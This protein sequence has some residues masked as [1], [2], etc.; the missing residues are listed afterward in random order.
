[1]FI[2][3]LVFAFISDN[4]YILYEANADKLLYGIFTD[5]INSAVQSLN[6]I[7]LNLVSELL[8]APHTINKPFLQ[9]Y[10]PNAN[11]LLV[12][13]SEPYEVL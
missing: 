2:E 10:E 5:V 12:V 11:V 13:G 8:D 4:L 6:V 7:L 1:M 9:S 3:T